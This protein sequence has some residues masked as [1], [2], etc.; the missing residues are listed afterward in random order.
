MTKQEFKQI[1]KNAQRAKRKEFEKLGIPYEQYKNLKL[2]KKQKN[3]IQ[4]A[5][6]KMGIFDFLKKKQNFKLKYKPIQS[7]KE[8]IDEKTKNSY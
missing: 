7:I 4:E 3:D 5:L 1:M 8:I 6:M 2:T